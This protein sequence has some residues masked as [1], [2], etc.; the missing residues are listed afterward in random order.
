MCHLSPT[1]LEKSIFDRSYLQTFGCQVCGL[2]W[3]NQANFNTSGYICQSAL[4][5]L[6]H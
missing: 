5:I 6:K 4:C 3:N 2:S 1:N